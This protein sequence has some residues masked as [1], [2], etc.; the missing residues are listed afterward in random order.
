MSFIWVSDPK[1]VAPYLCKGILE[2]CELA[3]DHFSGLVDRFIARLPEYRQPQ[4]FNDWLAEE[5]TLPEKIHLIF[6]K[7]YGD[8]SEERNHNPFL[9]PLLIKLDKAIREG[10]TDQFAKELCESFGEAMNQEGEPA[11]RLLL[12]HRIFDYITNYLQMF[13]TFA[14]PDSTNLE[15]SP[16]WYI[17]YWEMEL[18]NRTV[19]R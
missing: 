17:K 8:S 12:L 19:T 7:G 6:P 18:N 2:S 1:F 3:Q 14:D 5:H 13:V 11:E 9:W 15:F 4:D 10:T 16:E